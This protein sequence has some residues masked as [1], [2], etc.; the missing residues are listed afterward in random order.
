[1]KVKFECCFYVFKYDFDVS[2][3]CKI[4]VD[5]KGK[6]YVECIVWIKVMIY[7]FKVLQFGEQFSYGFD[8]VFGCSGV[9]VKIFK[10]NFFEQISGKKIVVKVK[11]VVLL[12]VMM[13]VGFMFK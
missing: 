1:M 5:K 7:K 2:Y 6:C 4:K 8:I 9:Q 10:G 3:S 11:V 13:I 12:S